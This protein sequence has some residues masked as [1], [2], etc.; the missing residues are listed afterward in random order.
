MFV[1]DTISSPSLPGD[2]VILV[3]FSEKYCNR[4][5][6]QGDKSCTQ[7]QYYQLNLHGKIPPMDTF[8]QSIFSGDA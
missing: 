4:R 5:K 3:F 6:L 8:M 1:L 2:C 7:Q